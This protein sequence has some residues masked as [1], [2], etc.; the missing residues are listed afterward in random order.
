[1]WHFPPFITL[2]TIRSWEKKDPEHQIKNNDSFEVGEKKGH[3]YIFIW[4]W[5]CYCNN[6]EMHS[7]SLKCI[8]FYHL[9]TV[10]TVEIFLGIHQTSS[11]NSLA[12]IY[13][14]TFLFSQPSIILLLNL[15]VKW[16]KLKVRIRSGSNFYSHCWG[17]SLPFWP[18]NYHDWHM[19]T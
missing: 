10:F 19:L 3:L 2:W 11:L 16:L 8:L 12:A 6:N 4:N 1:M 15:Y 18:S 5:W 9:A 13:I 7:V 14:I 17:S